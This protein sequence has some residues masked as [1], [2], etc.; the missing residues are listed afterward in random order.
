MMEWLGMDEQA[1]R[2]AFWL[3]VFYLG[4]GVL[5][6]WG[7]EIFHFLRFPIHVYRYRNPFDR[8]CIHCGYHENV[9]DTGFGTHWEAM[10]S[11]KAGQRCSRKDA[12]EQNAA[13]G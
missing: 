1:L 3:V 6:A 12:K 8:K 2:L 9:Y 5:F 13:L 11:G 7:R 10:D 4:C